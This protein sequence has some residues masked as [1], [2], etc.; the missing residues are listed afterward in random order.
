M[1][2]LMKIQCDKCKNI[3]TISQ[4]GTPTDA[5]VAEF[6][7]GWF[8]DPDMGGFDLCPECCGRNLKFWDTEPF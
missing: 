6:K 2:V 1:T 7:N 3:S 4:Y 5:R 8:F